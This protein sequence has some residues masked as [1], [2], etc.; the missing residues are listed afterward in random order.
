MHI[1]FNGKNMAKKL[2]DRVV[3]R[4]R[5]DKEQLEAISRYKIASVDHYT[6]LAVYEKLERDF[7]LKVKTF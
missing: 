2:Q 1:P 7:K 4:I 3:R 6:R 5:F